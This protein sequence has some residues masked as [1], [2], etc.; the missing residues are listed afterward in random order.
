MNDSH[1]SDPMEV[2]SDGDAVWFRRHPHRNHRIRLAEP[3]E[4][5]R[6]LDMVVPAGTLSFVVVRQ[7]FPSMRVRLPF[8]MSKWPSGREAAAGTLFEFLLRTDAAQASIRG[9]RADA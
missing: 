4:F 1:L 6:G 7:I 5:G 9:R 2:A 3:G 8:A